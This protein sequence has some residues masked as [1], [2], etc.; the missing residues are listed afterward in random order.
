MNS[1][2]YAALGVLLVAAVCSLRSLRRRQRTELYDD[3]DAVLL[4]LRLPQSRWFNMGYWTAGTAADDF[5]SAAAEL[6]RRV[7]Q[8]ARLK[9]HERVCEVGYGSGDSAL[10]FAREF[11]P[12]SYVGYTSLAGQHQLAARRAVEA[13]LATEGFELRRGDAARD[14]ATLPAGS[15]DVV[16][17]VDC[18]YHFNTRASFLD[19]AHHA[20]APL[21]RIA[22]TDLLIPVSDLS[23]VDHFLLR[24]LFHLAKAPWQ[25]FL[26]TSAYRDHLV[27]AGFDRDS[28]EMQD[29]SDDVWPGFCRFMRERDQQAGRST[30]LGSAWRGLSMYTKVVVWY[31]GARGGKRRLHFYL[32]SARKADLSTRG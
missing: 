11:E 29:I 31:S 10:L 13:K 6:C 26:T 2:T 5:P 30:I 20:L 17:A 25:N 3:A 4:N 28:I 27:Q 1:P 24:A 18:A 23:F 8:A 14:L 15:Q 19:G 16:L 21:G 12:R 22:L 32:I 7:A 9:A